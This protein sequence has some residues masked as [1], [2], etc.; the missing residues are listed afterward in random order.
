MQDIASKMKICAYNKAQ[1]YRQWKTK[2]AKLQAMRQKQKDAAKNQG[3][4]EGVVFGGFVPTGHGF[5]FSPENPFMSFSEEDGDF[6][7]DPKE[8]K[9]PRKRKNDEEES[10]KEDAAEQPWYTRYIMEKVQLEKNIQSLF[11]RLEK[12][13][14]IKISK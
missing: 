9:N 5:N 10:T 4:S 12:Y 7:K 8:P 2:T 11:S 3:P 6:D 14:Y 1:R 13:F